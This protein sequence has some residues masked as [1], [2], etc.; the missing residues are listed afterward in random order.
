MLFDQHTP[1]AFLG[2]GLMGTRMAARLLQAGYAV[3]VWNRSPQAC[4]T[5]LQ[6]GATAL[7]LEQIAAYPVVLTC[8]ADDHAVQSVFNQIQ[9]HLQAQQIIV[10]FSSLSVETTQQ[11]AQTAKQ[12]QITWIDSP[13]SGG[14]TGAEQGN[15]VIFAGGDGV[16]G[17]RL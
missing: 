8:L 7:A 13:V 2:M 17:F 15:L 14:T 5:L 1:I 16:G 3:A 10:D 11:L 12:Q 9:A 4:E 6:Q